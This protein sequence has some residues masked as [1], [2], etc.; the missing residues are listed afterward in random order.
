MLKTNQDKVNEHSDINGKLFAFII[1]DPSDTS[2]IY[3]LS[4][5]DTRTNYVKDFGL[6]DSDVV[7]NTETDDYMFEL[8]AENAEQFNDADILVVFSDENILEHIHS[9]SLLSEIEA[10]KKGA[11]AV[12]PNVSILSGSPQ[13]LLLSPLFVWYIYSLQIII[14]MIWATDFLQSS[15]IIFEN[16]RVEIT[17]AY[18]SNMEAGNACSCYGYGQILSMKGHHYE[19]WII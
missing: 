5:S 9:D 14:Q 1:V 7:A 4:K 17:E 2:V 13:R 6:V 11:V 3:V 16:L 10:V 8:S 12:L 15:L 19:F 18:T